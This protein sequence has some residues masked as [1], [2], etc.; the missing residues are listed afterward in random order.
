MPP[1]CGP[2]HLSDQII[3]FLKHPNPVIFAGAGVGAHVGFP[4]WQQFIEKLAAACETYTDNFSA[5]A[6][7]DRASRGRYL[8]AATIYRSADLIPEGERWKLL[9]NPFIKKLS[10]DT[11]DRLTPLVALPVTAIITTNYDR[12]LLHAWARYHRRAP[13]TPELGALSKSSLS[14][15][16]YIARVHGTAEK[17]QSMVFDSQ[18]YALLSNDPDYTDFIMDIFR[19]RSTLFV[20]YSFLDPAID[21][22]MKVYKERFGPTFDALHSA[23]VP[24]GQAELS[25]RLRA[26]N[27]EVIEYDPA[28][29][30]VALWRGFRDAYDRVVA[31]VGGTGVSAPPTHISASSTHRFLAFAYAQSATRNDAAP[32]TVV[33]HEGIV[34]SVLAAK[35]EALVSL[36]DLITEVASLLLLTS[37]ETVSIVQLSIERLREKDLLLMD[38]AALLWNGGE[39]TEMENDLQALAQG[40]VDRMQIREGIKLTSSEHSITA[41]ALEELLT[42]RA[43]DLAAQ[44][45]GAGVTW[46]ADLDC[47]VTEIV[48]R[49]AS[50]DGGVRTAALCRALLS[51]LYTPDEAESAKLTS[52]ARIAFGL[53]LILASPRQT[54][55][56]KYALPQRIYLDSNIVMPLIVPGHPLR[57]AYVDSLARLTEASAKTDF[58]LEVLVGEQFLNEVISHRQRAIDLVTQLKLEDPEKLAQHILFYSAINTNVFVGA[59]S[60]FVGRQRRKLS[61]AD[62]LNDVAPYENEHAL[63]ELLAALGIQTV[64]MRS[65]ELDDTRIHTIRNSLELAYEEADDAVLRGRARVLL[66]HEA[67]QLSRLSEDVREGRRSLFVTAHTRLRKL[68]RNYEAL[69]EFVGLTMS[70]VGLVAVAEVFGGQSI[71]P[72]ALARL[73]WA[74]PSNESEQELFNYFI[75]LGLQQYEEGLGLDMARAAEIVAAEAKQ[76]AKRE[77]IRLATDEIEDVART[78]RFLDRFEDRFYE[79]WRKGTERRAKQG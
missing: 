36:D 46:P 39:P 25:S 32:V 10:N 23:L 33:A 58:Q 12:S 45:A 13:L 63:S 29:N 56:H 70:H 54:L 44:L 5:Q 66:L 71:D 65:T 18:S 48:A 20:G 53:Q 22:I 1:R 47:Q 64:D 2:N 4:T 60:S 21:H 15:E 26:V 79:F 77:G 52:L 6:I 11:L 38:G 42:S 62:F 37:E 78:A 67:Q 27:I 40:V 35:G 74:A 14:R 68:L 61:F 43:W 34:A 75:D 72:R 50:S 73:L 3:S 8:E 51:L 7:R 9:A 41:R 24:M 55:L 16:P 30:H 57:P 49:I 76:S 59:Y 31:H 28:D 17:P 19:R 69:R